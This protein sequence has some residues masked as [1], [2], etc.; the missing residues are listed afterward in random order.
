MTERPDALRRLRSTHE[1]AVLGELRRSGAL[2]RSE[3]MERVGLSRSTLFAIVADLLERGAVHE[4]RARDRSRGRGRPALRLA[5]NSRG[6]E[7]IGLDLSRSGLHVVIANCAHETVARTSA[8]LQPD[9]SPAERAE[10]AVT[11][12]EKLATSLGVSLAPIQGIGLGLPGFVQDPAAEADVPTP[13]AREIAAALEA[14]LGAPVVTD[15]N[16]RLAA[17]AEATWG[18]ARGHGN[19][20]YLRWSDGVGGGFMVDGRLVRGAHGTAGE[21]GHTSCDPQ[22]P[23]CHCGGRGCLEGSVRI[24]VLLEACTARG[25]PVRD[26]AELAARAAAGDPAAVGV[27]GEAADAVGR[28]LAAAAAHTDPDCVV[29]DGELAGLDELVLAPVRRQL[30][31]LSLPAAQRRI[32]VRASAL[33]GYAAARGGV[34]LLLRRAGQESGG[35]LEVSPPQSPLAAGEG[36]ASAAE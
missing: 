15:N 7:L 13:E 11:T 25:T 6:A 26:A 28:V 5:L 17:L 35:L 14:R 21:I 23:F 34:A 27:V 3:L 12:L 20:V 16:A 4:Q 30:S 8:A 2:S 1:A 10:V 9:S 19:F 18:A 22:G 32:T 33:D 31:R 36:A 29:L 24:P